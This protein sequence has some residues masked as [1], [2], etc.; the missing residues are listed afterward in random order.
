MTRIFANR[1]GM[2]SAATDYVS[3]EKTGAGM[4]PKQVVIDGPFVARAK[5][6]GLCWMEE[7]SLI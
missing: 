5:A 3:G 1:R 6:P 4:I 7:H 2:L